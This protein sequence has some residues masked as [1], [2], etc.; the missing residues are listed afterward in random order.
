MSF[1]LQIKLIPSCCAA[2]IDPRMVWETSPASSRKVGIESQQSLDEEGLLEVFSPTVCSGL[3]LVS[4]EHP[5]GWGTQ[6]VRPGIS[7]W[8]VASLHH[9]RHSAASS[10][11]KE[12]LRW[13][14]KD[15]SS[16]RIQVVLAVTRFLGGE[17]GDGE[18]FDV[19]PCHP[20]M[21]T[22]T[23]ALSAP[24]LNSSFVFC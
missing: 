7:A 4:F 13:H 5:E 2:S 12:T 8:H 11:G 16:D 1:H 23:L 14:Y 15:N 18:E 21:R 20:H 19:V 6:R 24:K 9:H 17:K 3:C 10:S 22:W